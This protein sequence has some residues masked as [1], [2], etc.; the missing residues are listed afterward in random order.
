MDQQ[1][2]RDL[3]AQCVQECPPPCTA[4]CPLHV[5]VRALNAEVRQGNFASGLQIL[6]KSLPF[7]G[8]IGRICEQPCRSVCYRQ[9]AIAIASLEQA[10]ADFGESSSEKSTP[11]LPRKQR[12]A[13]VGGGLSG[14]TAAC[15]LAKKRYGVVIFEAR[16]SLGGSIW[17]IAEEQLPQSVIE[18][19]MANITKLGI[20]VRL[21]SPVSVTPTAGHISLSQLQREFEAVYLATGKNSHITQELSESGHLGVDPITYATNLPGLFAGGAMLGNKSAGSHIMAMSDGRRAAVSIDRHVQHVSLT[22]SRVNEGPYESCLYTNVQDEPVLP[23]TPLSAGKN[24]Y[25]R[26]EASAEARRCLQCECLE[27]VKT[28]EYL[29]EYGAYP[30][31]YAR[32]IYNNLSIVMG[33]RK[34]N[35]MI[36]SCSLCGLCAEICPND[37]DMSV[38][39]KEARQTMVAQDRM[40][41]SA[42]DFALRDLQF[43]NS[44]QFHLARHQPG[45]QNSAYLFFPGCQLSASDP[46]EVEQVYAYLCQKLSGGVG[47]LL[48]CCGVPA[49]WAGRKDLFQATLTE[50]SQQ[51]LKMGQPRVILACPSCY[52]VFKQNLPEIEIISLW[53]ILEQS[54]LPQ[55]KT[56]GSH[57]L[58]TIHDPC[59]S[60]HEP[61]MHESVRRLLKQAG[62]QIEELPLSREKTT[63]CSYGGEVW[64]A[65]PELSQKVVERRINDSPLDYVTYCAVCRD[66]FAMRGKRALHLLDLIWGSDYDVCATRRGPD[67]SQRHANRVHLKKQLLKEVWGEDMPV[68]NSYESIQLIIPEAVRD[69]LEQRLILE[70]DIQQ[71][72]EYAE[73]SGRRLR[74]AQSQHFLTHY[75]PNRVTYWVEYSLNE[76][77]YEIHNAYSHRMEVKEE[78][79][80]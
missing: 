9:E 79:K 12:V 57:G 64:L 49:D 66:F 48:H 27:C 43:S 22:A 29:S 56:E 42:H 71:V 28:C 21:N 65:N 67:Y 51:H 78:L 11:S 70:E 38:L 19:E 68:Q 2:L 62:Y 50:I 5:D 69:L 16:G 26:D 1:Q 14:L 53:E 60:R 41:P 80:K 6:K 63:C 54:G 44:E 8:I 7:P 32:T 17:S 23:V 47:L 4:A 75:R 25:S 52:Q 35:K 3:E 15:D 61:Q 39:C 45:M 40:P 10:C 24:A 77:V 18:A 46:Q 73:K 20:E 36:N 74:Q 72:I 59:S 58:I 30:K 13:I 31:K 76:G 37:L 55:S 33:E 34:A